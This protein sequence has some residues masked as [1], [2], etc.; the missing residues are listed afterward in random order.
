MG[1]KEWNQTQTYHF[2][3][4]KVVSLTWARDSYLTQLSMNLIM[5]TNVKMPA[6]VGILTL[7]SLINTTSE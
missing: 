4:F 7:M 2:I 5:L 3:N 1:R 6:I